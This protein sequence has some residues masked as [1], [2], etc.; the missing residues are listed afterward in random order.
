MTTIPKAIR[1]RI[2][3]ATPVPAARPGPP[4]DLTPVEDLLRRRAERLG[5]ETAAGTAAETTAASEPP[6]DPPPEPPRAAAPTPSQPLSGDGSDLFQPQEDGFDA[7]LFPTAAP[8]VPPGAAAP[9]LTP[10][11]IAGDA[12]IATIRAEGLTGRQ[13]RLARRTAQKHGIEASSDFEAVLLLRRRGIDPFDRNALMALERADAATA[14]QAAAVPT[15]TLARGGSATTKALARIDDAGA[16]TRVQ[17]PQT[18]TPAQVPA[19]PRGAPAVDEGTRA[20]EIIKI[21]RDIARRRRRR[22]ALLLARLSFFVFLP[23]LIAGWYYFVVATPMYATKTEFVIQKAD[24]MGG[25]GSGLGSLFSGTQLATNQ[26]SVTVQSFLQ[27][28]D[29]MLRLEADKG[30]KEHFSQPGID[31]IQ[32]LAPDATNEAAYKLYKRNVKIGYDP[33]EGL[34]RMEVIAAD[35][36]VS[37]AFSEALISYA[38][39]QV[40]KLTA[41]LRE[42][43]MRGARESYEDAEQKVFAAQGKVLELQEKVGILDPAAEGAGKMSQ[44]TGFET[45]LQKKRLE[46]GQLLDNPS[47]SPARVAGVRGDIS[48]LE[49]M[50]AELRRQLTEKTGST[51]SLASVT[52]QLR[53]AEAELETRQGLLAAAAQQMEVA[54]IEANKQVRYLEMGVRPVAP[55]EPTYP[56]AF[57]DTLLAFLVFSGIYLMLSLTASILREQVSS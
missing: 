13:L 39:G 8:R 28:R 26:D 56:R 44:V 46:L 14:A 4:A 37:K 17:L 22:I 6:S 48:R 49:T 57:E 55:D 12:D 34:I 45:E 18:I 43:Q 30:F 9:G 31:P 52:G 41:R 54:R 27:S 1:Y 10:A 50:I 42:D 19:P 33:S 2:R 20:R 24:S 32:R 25:G 36:Q 29:A 7:A 16:D 3:P 40:D 51:E 15:P 35:P 53:I 38:E 21:Q 5:A 47:P 11:E 23:T